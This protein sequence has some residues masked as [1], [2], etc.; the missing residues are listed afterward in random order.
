MLISRLCKCFGVNIFKNIALKIGV[1]FNA[2]IMS[3][4][5]DY[6]SRAQESEFR[7]VAFAKYR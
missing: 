5:S 1:M 6:D 2:L 4:V 3:V 7:C